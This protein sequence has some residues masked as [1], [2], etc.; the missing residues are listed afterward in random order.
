MSM[1][2]SWVVTRKGIIKGRGLHVV[3]LEDREEEITKERDRPLSVS[4]L[5]LPS[6]ANAERIKEVADRRM[7]RKTETRFQKVAV[8]YQGPFSGSVSCHF[9]VLPLR[10]EEYGNRE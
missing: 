3:E 8:K 6:D 1:T 4:G 2:G 9:R 10:E 7:E 5:L